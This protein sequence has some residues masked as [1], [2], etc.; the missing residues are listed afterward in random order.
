MNI[1]VFKKINDSVNNFIVLFNVWT[2]HVPM[3]ITKKYTAVMFTKEKKD[4]ILKLL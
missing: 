2:V 3:R 4:V 1:D